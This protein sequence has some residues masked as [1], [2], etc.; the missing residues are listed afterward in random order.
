MIHSDDD[1]F[2]FS[3]V[4]FLFICFLFT[5]F[6]I[7]DGMLIANESFD[8]EK[9]SLYNLTIFAFDG[10]ARVSSQVIVNILPVNEFDPVIII[11]KTVYNVTEG[12]R[13]L[14]I[15]LQVS[16]PHHNN[17]STLNIVIL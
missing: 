7:S 13:R 4:L 6:T 16:V 12:D 8:Y 14:T 15:C 9:I 10:I 11:R 5:D 17:E 3:V 1:H 2:I